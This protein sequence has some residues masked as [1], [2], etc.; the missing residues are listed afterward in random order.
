[1]IILFAV[2]LKTTLAHLH[3]PLPTIP[4]LGLTGG[5]ALYLLAHVALRYRIS[6]TLGHGRPIAT[7]VLIGLFPLAREVPALAA[8]GLVA[9]VCAGLIA[10]ESLRYPYAREWIR[11]RRGAFTMDEAQRIAGTRG[12]PRARSEPSNDG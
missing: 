5:V 11:S 3:D 1:G 2:G 9:A 8:L 4:A 6:R 7:L 10:Y 12:R